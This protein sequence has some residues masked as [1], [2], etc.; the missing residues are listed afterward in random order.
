M[1]GDPTNKYCLIQLIYHDTY[2]AAQKLLEHV[3]G[4]HI[5]SPN[6]KTKLL[7]DKHAD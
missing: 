7:R 4:P 1:T 2:G 5:L 3:N 6:H